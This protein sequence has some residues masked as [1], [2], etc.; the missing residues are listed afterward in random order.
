MVGGPSE[1]TVFA[2]EDNSLIVSSTDP[3]LANTVY[4]LGTLQVGCNLSVLPFSTE[5][6][7]GLGLMRFPVQSQIAGR[8]ILSAELRL[9]PFTLG[10]DQ[11]TSFRLGAVTHAWTT[12]TVTANSLLDGSEVYST[13]Q[14]EQ[15]APITTALPYTFDVTTIVRNW[16]NGSFANHGLLL[17]DT[18]GFP[19]LSVL[20][21][22]AFDS[23]DD[24]AT[25]S[26][27]PQRIIR[28]Q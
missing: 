27:R 21:S 19:A 2:N 6:V 9:Y 20:R 11:Q 3:T 16:A 5:Y 28:F 8:T 22:V 1:I 25:Q 10:A 7:C 12:T 15:P 24:F 4:R 17:W 23:A 13:G 14:S 26:T 18:A